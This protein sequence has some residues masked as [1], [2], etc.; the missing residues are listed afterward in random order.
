M[1]TE[2]E[3]PSWVSTANS[4]H[5]GTPRQ[6]KDSRAV[7]LSPSV[8][9]GLQQTSTPTHG[10]QNR[11]VF[12]PV[13]LSAET[14]KL[15]QHP[16]GSFSI[17]CD[18]ATTEPA[19]SPVSSLPAGADAVASVSKSESENRST[20]SQ[21]ARPSAPG[22]VFSHGHP[23]HHS[24][25]QQS[26][27]QSP[28]VVNNL[29]QRVK[30]L[31]IAKINAEEEVKAF[32]KSYA[33]IQ[34]DGKKLY[35]RYQTTQASLEE[36]QSRMKRQT[37][38][39]ATLQRENEQ[40]KNELQTSRK[41]RDDWVA[42]FREQGAVMKGMVTE[43]SFANKRLAD[44]QAHMDMLTI[45]IQER[46]RRM[47]E[48]E[49][50]QSEKM[51]NLRVIVETASVDCQTDIKINSATRMED[52]DTS[53]AVLARA[54]VRMQMYEGAM[55]RVSEMLDS[56]AETDAVLGKTG[57]CLSRG[58]E[59]VTEAGIS[60][61]EREDEWARA[62]EEQDDRIV[63]LEEKIQLQE[64]TSF[65]QEEH[66]QSAF[67]LSQREDVLGAESDSAN[68]SFEVVEEIEGQQ[69]QP[70]VEM[71]E[72]MPLQQHKQE[73]S[74]V[75]T[76]LQEASEQQRLV[77]Q[78]REY[79]L[80]Q[81]IENISAKALALQQQ[82]E[83]TSSYAVSLFVR[84]LFSNMVHQ[85]AMQALSTAGQQLSQL[86]AHAEMLEEKLFFLE[87]ER[88]VKQDFAAELQADLSTLQK[89]Y[90]ELE[91]IARRSVQEFEAERRKMT[92]EIERLLET[93]A[94]V[95]AELTEI[96]FE[97]DALAE[98]ATDAQFRADEQVNSVQQKCDAM[99]IELERLRKKILELQSANSE[100]TSS[101]DRERRES[102]LVRKEDERKL[103]MMQDQ[104]MSHERQFA[105][106]KRAL[107]MWRSKTEAAQ[108]AI[109]SDVEMQRQRA[110]IDPRYDALRIRE[111][112]P[113]LG[114]LADK[115]DD[116]DDM[117]DDMD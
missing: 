89:R 93:E 117:D 97:R 110:R 34:D 92:G 96:R 43:A 24:A 109:R 10:H 114:D 51:K 19:H 75:T 38:L 83:Q 32:R 88:D 23:H 80:C 41:E 40:L 42:K 103:R 116:E 59:R 113:K 71:P 16:Q 107:Q 60:L 50:A 14:K 45:E 67:P 104:V 36:V 37:D 111:A 62:L 74:E 68:L 6:K 98:A 58:I 78:H 65:A 52:H 4:G 15:Q 56:L 1:D 12:S 46:E 5:V 31:E 25:V 22:P 115:W 54:S 20:P 55:H 105:E 28:S 53:I 61:Q 99:R 11:L 90:E 27:N 21:P 35:D 30:S 85:E 2:K 70:Q 49:A 81:N 76:L 39:L 48:W 26:A 47:M 17:Y 95:Q 69:Q 72:M 100:L 29:Q 9:H 101:V 108:T 84:G 18:E 66:E 44:A 112:W 86:S 13:P 102:E 8:R 77:S 64:S 106:A 3:N 91:D 7:I 82:Q 33:K 73:M 79:E 94:G 87:S 63:A 57:D